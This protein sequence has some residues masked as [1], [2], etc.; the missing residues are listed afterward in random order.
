MADD[1]ADDELFED[2]VEAPR[3]TTTPTTPPRPCSHINEDNTVYCTK[4]GTCRKDAPPANIPRWDRTTF[5][6]RIEAQITQS[7]NWL[8]KSKSHTPRETGVAAT[9][10][11]S[12][13]VTE[14]N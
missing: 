4:C 7:P 2:G 5:G 11:S 14:T 12:K 3:T 6:S 8:S 1:I 9:E 10:V 13:E